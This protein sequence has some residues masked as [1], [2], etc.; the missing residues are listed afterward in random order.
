MWRTGL[1][2]DAQFTSTHRTTQAQ[3]RAVPTGRSRDSDSM[4]TVEAL[5]LIFAVVTVTIALSLLAY[6]G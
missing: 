3:N 4:S 1:A 6:L 5:L 2:D